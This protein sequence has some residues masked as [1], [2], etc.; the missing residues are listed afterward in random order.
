MIL[1]MEI[2]GMGEKANEEIHTVVSQMLSLLLLYLLHH[3]ASKYVRDG[4]CFMVKLYKFHCFDKTLAFLQTLLAPYH[5][6][7]NILTIH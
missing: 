1:Y 6:L 7:L 3:I 2:W 4:A 5:S